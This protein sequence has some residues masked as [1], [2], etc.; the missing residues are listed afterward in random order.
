MTGLRDWKFFLH[1]QKT[2]FY[3]IL[4]F[5]AQLL[6]EEVVLHKKNQNHRFI[7]SFTIITKTLFFIAH[8]LP[9]KFHK[10]HQLSLNKSSI[11]FF[12]L[13]F[14]DMFFLFSFYRFLN[15]DNQLPIQW[16]RRCEVDNFLVMDWTDLLSHIR[17]FLD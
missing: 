10:T 13:N 11:K 8:I 4:Y 5:D 6:F 9:Q 16:H 3:Y 14:S 17:H 1:F 7:L 2:F 12:F 15:H